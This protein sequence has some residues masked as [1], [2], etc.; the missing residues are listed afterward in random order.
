MTTSE[1]IKVEV[2]TT[3]LQS[4][5]AAIA[6]G[7]DRLELCSNLNSGGLTPSAALIEKAIETGIPVNVLV[8]PRSGNF[9]Y[10]ESEIEIICHEIELLKKAGAAGIVCGFLLPNGDIDEQLCTRI[11]KLASP[12][13]FTFHRAFDVCKNPE[14]SLEKI[15]NAGCDRLLTS[16]QKNKAIDGIELISALIQQ[17][18]NRIII[19]PGSGVNP[20][21]VLQF[22]NCGAKEVHL[23]GTVEIK[24]NFIYHGNNVNM[25]SDDKS[26]NQILETSSE[27]IKKVKTILS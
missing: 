13:S 21:N 14:K 18:K 8:R 19:M 17:A 5:R 2:C 15:I 26:N 12:M 3:S 1:K 9:V 22:V 25:S 24:N 23:S 10:S 11:R 7:A 27:I 4:A 6:G 20:N 16:G